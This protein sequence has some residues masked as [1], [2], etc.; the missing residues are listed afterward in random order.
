MTNHL[1]N[2]Q[3]GPISG[4]SVYQLVLVCCDGHEI[5]LREDKCFEFFGLQFRDV[6][7]SVVRVPDDVDSRL[8]LVHGVEN[9]LETTIL[10]MPHKS[11]F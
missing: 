2:V 4:F 8:V 5:R 3:Y 1:C 7:L 10:W 6:Q 9:Y 11:Q